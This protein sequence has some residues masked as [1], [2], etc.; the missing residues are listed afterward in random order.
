[1]TFR[2]VPF[3]STF[4]LLC[5]I[6]IVSAVAADSDSKPVP[7]GGAG[8]FVAVG[9]GGRRISSRDGIA[10]ENDQ[11][12]SEKAADDDN[13]LFNVAF[14]K[15]KFVVVG[16]ASNGHILI[17]RNGKEYTE[18]FKP[19]GRVATV[20]FGNGMFVAGHGGEYLVSTD[21]ETW[22]AGSKFQFNGGLHQRKSAFGNGV[23]VTIGDADPGW[24]NRVA[25]RSS[26]P[27]GVKTASFDVN[28]PPARSIAFGAGRF[29][30]VGPDGLRES[31]TDG[32][33]WEHTEKLPGENLNSVI[34]T[35]TQFIA[36]GDKSA[37]TS[38]DGIAW[39]Q[40]KK[41]I[42]CTMLFADK[43]IM[44]GASWGG[45]IFNSTNGLDWK[46]GAIKAGNSFEA[47][48]FGVPV[49]PA[50]LETLQK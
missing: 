38:P 20:N 6:Q 5:F 43:D 12:W 45:N 50:A 22:T 49:A 25:F 3:C 15:G 39:T 1:M 24:K 27:D 2:W 7:N 11:Q 33:A 4:F 14:G 35:G 28:S 34:W 10:W 18:V 47:V 8:L 32:K 26:T 40:E 48:S 13:V 21:G 46:K 9:Y 42:P 31:S 30:V 37:F 17:T 29:V 36:G 44:I 16:G 19:K 23:F 41:H